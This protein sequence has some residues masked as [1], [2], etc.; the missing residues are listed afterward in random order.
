MSS[1]NNGCAYLHGKSIRQRAQA[2]INIA[3]PK[4]RGQLTIALPAFRNE[5]ALKLVRKT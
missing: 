1:R 3:H 5:I 4:F 2:L